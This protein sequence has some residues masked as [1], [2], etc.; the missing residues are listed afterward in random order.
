MLK[1]LGGFLGWDTEDGNSQNIGSKSSLVVSRRTLS[2]SEG[3]V[4]YV[5]RFTELCAR[6]AFECELNKW[7]LDCDLKLRNLHSLNLQQWPYAIRTCHYNNR[8]PYSD[9][10][11]ES[12]I[13]LKKLHDDLFQSSCALLEL[14]ASHC[15]EYRGPRIEVLIAICI[16]AAEVTQEL[17]FI[18][19]SRQ[20]IALRIFDQAVL[21]AYKD[22]GLL[23]RLSSE[24]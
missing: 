15:Q 5:S 18:F 13:C 22:N 16:A 14:F 12:K 6:M 10:D 23:Y 9:E 8:L 20:T 7:Y 2:L 21:F 1:I 3:D 24:Q 11:R 17:T 19:N 4:R